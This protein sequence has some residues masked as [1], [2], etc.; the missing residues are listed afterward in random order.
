MNEL[1]EINVIQKTFE[2]IKHIDK[3]GLEYWYAKELMKLLEYS[4]WESFHR[5]IKKAE[6]SCKNSGCIIED[7]FFNIIKSNNIIEEII[8]YKLTR[9]AC[10]IIIINADPRKKVVALGKSYIAI[11][12]RKRELAEKELPM[13]LFAMSQAEQKIKR[14]GITDEAEANE[15]RLKMEKDVRNL[16]NS[17]LKYL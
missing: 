5:V 8:D 17:Q 11:Q 6:V 16:V 1:E 4:T 7:N 10:Y 3:N 13:K 14:E 2:D 12:T 9:F 15:I